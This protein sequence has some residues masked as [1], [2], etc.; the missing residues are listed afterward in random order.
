LLV[1]RPIITKLAGTMVHGT[2]RQAELIITQPQ[3]T[4]KLK[5]SSRRQRKNT[6]TLYGRLHLYGSVVGL[7][8]CLHQDAG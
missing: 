5:T 2:R 1:A 4:V 3:T 7:T 8:L 6:S